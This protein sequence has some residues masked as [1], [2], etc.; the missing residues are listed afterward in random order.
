MPGET[1]L[2]HQDLGQ[3]RHEDVGVVIGVLGVWG[4]DDHGT[5][6]LLEFQ[7]ADLGTEVGLRRSSA[8]HSVQ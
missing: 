8:S 7:A 2:I 6:V 3:L 5:H 1:G 4:A